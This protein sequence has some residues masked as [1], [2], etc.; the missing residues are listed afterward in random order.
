MKPTV[1]KVL[2]GAALATVT[3]AANAGVITQYGYGGNAGQGNTGTDDFGNPWTWNKTLGGYTGPGKGYSA[4]GTPGLGLG[5][6]TYEGANPSN[7]FDVSFSYFVKTAIDEQPATVP[8]V[9]YEETTRFVV[10]GVLWT[11]TYDG[12]KSVEFDAPAGTWITKGETFFVNV[13]FDKK[14]LSGANAGFSAEWSATV[15]EASTWAMLGI[16]FAGIGVVGLTR[17]RKGSR[18]AL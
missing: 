15:P 5:E 16:G 18:Y 13:V 2:A 8:V 14:N 7:D 3:T 10:N 4:W 12:T 1:L 6:A 11:P 17:R 9:N